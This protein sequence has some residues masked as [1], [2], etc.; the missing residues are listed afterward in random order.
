IGQNALDDCVSHPWQ[1][2]NT[3]ANLVQFDAED[4]GTH[5]KAGFRQYLVFFDALQAGDRQLLNFESRIG[6]Q[7]N[8]CEISS[9]SY[10]DQTQDAQ[11]RGDD[12]ETFSGEF[13]AVLEKRC[14]SVS[15]SFVTLPAPIT[16]MAS[17]D[18][19]FAAI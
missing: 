3:F 8:H 15:E 17:P 6:C 4:V 5:F 13:H 7:K 1:L 19:A 11:G 2:F 12:H 14:E 9:P 10:R 18:V 16:T